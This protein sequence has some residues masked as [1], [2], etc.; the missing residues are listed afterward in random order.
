MSPLIP[1]SSLTSSPWTMPALGVGTGSGGSLSPVLVRPA[2]PSSIQPLFQDDAL[3]DTA[4]DRVT[5]TGAFSGSRPGANAGSSSTDGGTAI[6]ASSSAKAG[7][8]AAADYQAAEGQLQSSEEAALLG[9][10]GSAETGNSA[11][12]MADLLTASVS[13]NAKAAA[14]GSLIQAKLSAYKVDRSA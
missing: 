7:T 2:G 1:V 6:G 8:T 4:I 12:G 11:G 10:S 3:L 13:G 14:Y 9:T 5:L